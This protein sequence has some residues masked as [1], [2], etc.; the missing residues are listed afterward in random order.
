VANLHDAFKTFDTLWGS[1]PLRWMRVPCNSIPKDMER[2]PVI[3]D[4]QLKHGNSLEAASHQAVSEDGEYKE[5]HHNVEPVTFDSESHNREGN[6]S[7][8]SGNQEQKPE[9]D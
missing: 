5:G 9:L 4:R 6:T 3:L 1:I 2:L 8:R 7:H